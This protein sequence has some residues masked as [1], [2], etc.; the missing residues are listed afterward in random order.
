MLSDDFLHEILGSRLNR[1]R[2]KEPLY[3]GKCLIFRTQ[4]KMLAQ[5]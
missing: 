5:H 2:R 4:T 3:D 1:R